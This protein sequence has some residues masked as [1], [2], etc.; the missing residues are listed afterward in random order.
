MPYRAFYILVE[1]DDDERFFNRLV[2]PVLEQVYDY[3]EVRPFAYMKQEKVTALVRSIRAMPADY[4]FVTDINSA[5]CISAKKQAVQRTYNS[6][7]DANTLIVVEEIES[8]YL[9]GLD[10]HACR[11]FGIE[12][13][14]RTDHVS[15]E[16]FN[17]LLSREY[18]SKINLM[19]EI[20]NN[21][22]I[23]TARQGNR[24]FDY[25]IRKHVQPRQAAY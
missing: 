4:L 9:A 6:V 22:S 8:W 12:F 13:I 2:K 18:D 3:V 11:R 7:E 23:D 19:I 25:L 17:R 5:P 1:G 20:L 16:S 14:G 24:S 15:K 21:F 10:H